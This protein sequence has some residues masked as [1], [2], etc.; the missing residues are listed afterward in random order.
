MDTN[1][2]TVSLERKRE[3]LLLLAG[4][5]I[6]L[7]I[8]GF[9]ALLWFFK[10]FP[11]WSSFLPLVWIIPG[12]IGW[13]VWQVPW[14]L[15][16]SE[17]KELV[18]VPAVAAWRP[19]WELLPGKG[20]PRKALADSGLS[21]HPA[22]Q[23]YAED[24]VRGTVDGIA[25]E[26]AEIRATRS[27]RSAGGKGK[28]TEVLFQGVL[29]QATLVGQGEAASGTW[30]AQSRGITAS[31]APLPGEAVSA[32]LAPDFAR[33]FVVTFAGK[34]EPPPWPEELCEAVLAASRESGVRFRLAWNGTTLWMGTTSL[35][36]LWEPPL[37]TRLDR[38]DRVEKALRILGA[39]EALVR[40]FAAHP[41]K[42]S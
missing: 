13:F 2:S 6:L 4:A 5:G 33:E 42:G 31:L 39:F 37:W 9:A 10:A 32:A 15:L 3:R 38:P 25:V 17:W 11:P 27:V 23:Y 19:G 40:A 36:D 21:A 18:A 12:V 34:E 1:P 20:L 30:Y 7:W 35:I 24:L 26:L 28:R 41:V 29:G 14:T 22:S 8:S 16:Q